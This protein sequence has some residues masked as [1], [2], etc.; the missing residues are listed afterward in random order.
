VNRIFSA[1]VLFLLFFC[2][3]AATWAVQP[4]DWSARSEP[5][6]INAEKLE[7]FANENQ[8][9][10]QGNVEAVQGAFSLRADYLKVNTQ[11][12]K[13][14]VKTAW[15]E[16]NVRIEKDDMTAVAEKVLYDVENASVELKT[17]AKVWRNRD[18]AAG[19]LI[20]LRLDDD[21]T[22]VEQAEVVLYSAG[23]GLEKTASNPLG[24]AGG[25]EPLRV[26][27]DKLTLSKSKGV[28]TFSGNVTAAKGPLK[29]WADWAEARFDTAAGELKSLKAEGD[30]KIQKDE[31]TATSGKAAYE[32]ESNMVALEDSPKVRRGRDCM[33]GNS[34]T[35]HLTDNKVVING[36]SGVFPPADASG[37]LCPE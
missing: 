26:K 33:A 35:L 31:V 5:L 13:Q 36:A 4:P 12:D 14:N 2:C 27:A 19:E 8:V 9:V 24:E 23:D 28:A 6:R 16:G 3:P 11:G 25:D 17:Q 7:V 30:V 18:V 32:V 34:M 37:D 21:L 29:L 1:S 15:A 22:E 20:K 10:F